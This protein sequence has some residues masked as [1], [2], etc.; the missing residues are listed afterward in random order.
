FQCTNVGLYPDV[1]SCVIDDKSF[2]N[3]VETGI[4]LIYRPETTMFMKHVI[5]AGG[6]ACNGLKMLIYQAVCAYEIWNDV[7]VPDEVIRD[8]EQMLRGA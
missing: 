8:L 6:R 7:K 2:Y 3:K 5:S 1:D 4:D